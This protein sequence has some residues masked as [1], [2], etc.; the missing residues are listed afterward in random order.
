LLLSEGDDNQTSFQA[1]VLIV[2]KRDPLDLSTT[3]QGTW[4]VAKVHRQRW[5]AVVIWKMR[6]LDVDGDEF[7]AYGGFALLPS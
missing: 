3:T 4:A 5:P 7:V 1:K 2:L 6:W